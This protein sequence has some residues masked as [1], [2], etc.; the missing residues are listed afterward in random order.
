[1]RIPLEQLERGFNGLTTAGAVIAYDESLVAVSAML[2]RRDI[3]WT[4][5]LYAL[6]DSG[7]PSE[8]LRGYGIVYA[9]LEASFVK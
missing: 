7:R 4:Q 8:T 6:A 5:L 9:D 3:S 1:M 2:E